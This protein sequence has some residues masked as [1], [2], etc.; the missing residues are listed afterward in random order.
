MT[1]SDLRANVGLLQQSAGHDPSK[2][3]KNRRGNTSKDRS[4]FEDQDSDVE[5]IGE[6]LDTPIADRGGPLSIMMIVT[7]IQKL[8]LN[9]MGIKNARL[10]LPILPVRLLEI[11]FFNG[12]TSCSDMPNCEDIQLD[13]QKVHRWRKVKCSAP[14]M[15]NYPPI[16]FDGC[17]WIA[18]QAQEE[19]SFFLEKK[20]GV[21]DLC[22]K[23]E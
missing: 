17:Q 3:K 6:S 22:M 11:V 2:S 23:T 7:R 21:Y 10:S 18:R 4:D 9:V 20:V 12:I 13:G 14:E 16:Y 19:D 8:T 15:E 1:I 5:Q